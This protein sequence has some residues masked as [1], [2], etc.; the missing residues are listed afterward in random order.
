MK[1]K[2]LRFRKGF[3]VALSSPRGQVAEMVLAAGDSEGDPTN[4]HK[5]SD[6]WL[7]VVQGTGTAFVNER[8]VDLRPGCLLLIERGDRHEIKNT[9]R[10]LLK[11]LN[12]YVPRAYSNR[13]RALPAARAS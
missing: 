5:G 4:R 12:F 6:Q 3:R 7:Y 13:G 1:R 11:T 9:G 2:T 8:R 10:G